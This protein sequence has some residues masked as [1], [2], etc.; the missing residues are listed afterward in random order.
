MVHEGRMRR[1][2][3]W[4]GCGMMTMMNDDGFRRGPRLS[5]ASKHSLVTDYNEMSIFRG[6]RGRHGVAVESSDCRRLQGCFLFAT[7]QNPS[8]IFSK[9]VFFVVV[10]RGV[11]CPFSFCRVPCPSEFDVTTHLN[12]I[13]IYAQ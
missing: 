5:N 13:K 9:N 1:R 12:F 3:V 4:I 8:E 10:V 7:H 2:R 11:T 6:F